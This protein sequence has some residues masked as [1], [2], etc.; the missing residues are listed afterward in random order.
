[1]PVKVYDG[2]NW[3]TVAG[4]GQAGAPGSPGTSSSIATWVKTASGGETS[5][6][7]TGDTG[8]GTLAYTVGQELVY[9]N[10]VLLDRGDDYTATNGTSITGLTALLAGDVITVW[11][12]NSFSVANTYTQAQANAAFAPISVTGGMTLLNAGG[13]AMSG[14][15]TSVSINSTGYTALE[16]F[17]KDAYVNTNDSAGF[18]RINGD[19]G[20]NYLFN[21]IR[22]DGGPSV[23]GV[24]QNN[25][26]YIYYIFNNLPSN[27]T[28]LLKGNSQITLFQ[29]T[30][31]TNH[32]VHWQSVSSRNDGLTSST[33]GGGTYDSTAAVTSISLHPG[34]GATWSGG[35]IY[36]YGVK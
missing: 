24:N 4:D 11:T 13:T 26:P 32:S 16:I 8:Y 18:L 33:V 19:S 29:P 5:V 3:V 27:N 31:S 14:A 2:T 35:T 25:A 7:G 20:N 23:T 22:F 28:T 36:V 21:A 34:G 12:V 6:S 30:V 10:G 15:S 1:M 9:L 17:I